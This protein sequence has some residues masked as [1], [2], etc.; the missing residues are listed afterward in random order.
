MTADY[1]C[2]FYDRL[3]QQYYGPAISLGS[4]IDLEWARIP[5]FYYNLRLPVRDRLCRGDCHNKITYG[6][7]EDKEKYLDSISPAPATT[8]STSCRRPAST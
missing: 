8:R 7:Q 6:S 1:L 3:N 4:D 2:G 5:H